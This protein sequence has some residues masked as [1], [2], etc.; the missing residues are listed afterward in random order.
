M[1]DTKVLGTVWFGGRHTIGV[2][3]V[4]D[5]YDGIKY[6]IGACDGSLNSEADDIQ[7]IVDWGSYFPA[8]AGKALF[9]L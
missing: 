4:E 3:K 6:L 5:K 9:D 1:S 7:Y 2:V 8:G